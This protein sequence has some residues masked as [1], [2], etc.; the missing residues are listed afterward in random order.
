MV[1]IDDDLFAEFDTS[2]V[3]VTNKNVEGGVDIWDN[4]EWLLRFMN[5][6]HVDETNLPTTDELLL[7]ELLIKVN[8]LW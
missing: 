3:T 6:T 2:S 4:N 1:L 7:R 8:K 5:N